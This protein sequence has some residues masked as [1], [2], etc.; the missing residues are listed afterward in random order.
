M[1]LPESW[2]LDRNVGGYAPDYPWGIFL[3]KY[4]LEEDEKN[5]LNSITLGSIVIG[6]NQFLKWDL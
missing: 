2:I 5:L 3:D 4:P 6:C 1:L